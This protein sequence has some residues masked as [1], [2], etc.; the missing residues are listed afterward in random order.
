M[1]RKTSHRPGQRL[2]M[3]QEQLPAIQGSRFKEKRLIHDAEH[4][5]TRRAKTAPKLMQ[6]TVAQLR[7]KHM[8]KLGTHSG[9]L[10]A[11]DYSE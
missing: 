4:L 2:R 5:E 9:G 10:R 3:A 11:S 6:L 1:A 8:S 7:K